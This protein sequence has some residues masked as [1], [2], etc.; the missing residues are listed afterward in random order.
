MDHAR[1]PVETSGPWSLVDR[2][3]WMHDR[4]MR[5]LIVYETMY[6]STRTIAEHIALGLADRFEATLVPVADAT[7]D[8]AAAADLVVCGAPTH[9]HGLPRPGTRRVAVDG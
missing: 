1:A 7:T 3:R 9:A 2:S 4:G 6:G 8:L 5:A